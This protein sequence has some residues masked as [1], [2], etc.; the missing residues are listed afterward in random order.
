MDFLSSYMV[1]AL[2]EMVYM[3][4]KQCCKLEIVYHSRDTWRSTYLEMPNDSKN[5][6]LTILSSEKFDYIPG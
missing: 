2:W 4:R 3:N 5:K 1:W 6:V